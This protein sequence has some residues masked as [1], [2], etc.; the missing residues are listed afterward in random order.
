[1]R[2]RDPYNSIGGAVDGPASNV[3]LQNLKKT[4]R[5]QLKHHSIGGVARHIRISDGAAGSVAWDRG[6]Q[7]GANSENPIG[8]GERERGRA[9][10]IA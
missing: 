7:E 3:A 10:R 1:M 5:R 4:G 2:R 8:E 9:E 6:P